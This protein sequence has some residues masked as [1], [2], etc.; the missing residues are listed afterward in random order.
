MELPVTNACEY[1]VWQRTETSLLPVL[2]A[3]RE[4]PSPSV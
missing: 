3:I 1:T 4:R 2:R